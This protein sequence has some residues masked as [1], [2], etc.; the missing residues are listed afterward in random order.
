VYNSD[1][2]SLHNMWIA[3][4]N[5]ESDDITKVRGFLRISISVL[6]QKDDRV[7]LKC[8]SDS[9]DMCVVPPQIKMEYRQLKIYVIKARDLPNMDDYSVASVLGLGKG[10]RS[11]SNGECDGYVKLDYMGQSVKSSTVQ[12]KS[13]EILWNE[14]IQMAVSYPVI[15]QRLVFSVWDYD[16][17]GKDEIVGSFEVNVN[18]IIASKYNE[19][20]YIHLYGAPMNVNNTFSKKMDENPEVGSLWRGRILVRM[21]AE[22]T[23]SPINSLKA[24]N[25]TV[26]KEKIIIKQSNEVRMD[27]HWKLDFYLYDLFYLPSNAKYG[28]NIC[29]GEKS[30]QVELRKAVN[31]NIKLNITDNLFID[32]IKNMPEDI[33][34]IF[35][36]LTDETGIN[37]CFQR[38]KAMEFLNNKDV[39]VIKLFPDHTIGKIKC[40]FNSGIL[41]ARF[42][43]T[44][45]SNIQIPVE[46][47]P[48]DPTKQAIDSKPPTA[49]TKP[50]DNKNPP[51]KIEE[52]PES[53]ESFGLGD[54]HKKKQNDAKKVDVEKKVETRYT[55]V[56]NVH[57]SR[58]LV[59]MDRGGKSDPYVTLKV[60]EYEMKTGVKKNTLNGIWNEKL[61]FTDLE[62]DINDKSSWPIMLVK[63][64]D[65]DTFNDE[66][67]AYSYIWLSDSSYCIGAL[68]QLRPSYIQ[69]FL[70]V[71]N[72]P[73]GQLLCSFIILDQTSQQDLI[74]NHL[75]TFKIIP[76]VE[77]YSFEINILGLRGL[78][79]L[80]LLPIKKA[81]ID[82]DLQSINVLGDCE[83][84]GKLTLITTQPKQSGNHPTINTVIK[85]DA[86]LPKDKVFMSDLQCVVKD[87]LLKGL[88]KQ[89]LGIFI[90]PISKI[91]EETEREMEEDIKRTSEK[92]HKASQR[93]TK[94]KGMKF[95]E[96]HVSNVVNTE[97]VNLIEKLQ[98]DFETNKTNNNDMPERDVNNN[99]NPQDIVVELQ[100]APKIFDINDPANFIVYPAY[101]K[102]KVPGV[103]E[104]SKKF[105]LFDKEDRSKAPD[106]K[107]YKAI[108]FN[109]QKPP[110]PEQSVKHYRRIFPRPLEEC[111]ELGISKPF[112]E[113]PIKRSKFEDK[114]EASDMFEA[115]R[116]IKSK[117]IKKYSST[118][119]QNVSLPEEI[120]F[121]DKDFGIF[122]GVINICQKK[123]QT[124]FDEIVNTIKSK[125]PDIV[126][127]LKFL[128]KYEDLSR[129]ILNPKQV[130]IRIYI[131]DLKNLAKKDLL[132]ETDPY[133]IVKLGSTVI[134]DEVSCIFDKHTTGW[135]K[136]YELHTTLPGDGAL[137]VE[138]WDEDP[139][140]PDEL[141]GTTMID[142]EDR[143]FDPIWR[144]LKEKPIETRTLLHPDFE[145]P[146]GEV[147]LW[148]DIF[149]ASDNNVYKKV[150]ITP[151][152]EST[153]ELRMIVWETEDIPF[154]DDEETT[155]LYMCVIQGNTRES[156]DTHYRCQTGC[157]S[158]NWRIL[159]PVIY[160]NPD[161]LVTIQAYDNDL[162]T[163]DDFISK[164]T[165]D[166]RSIIEDCY[167][168][169]VPIKVSLSH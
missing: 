10:Q 27:F 138:V 69:L 80:N 60:G 146:Q 96:Q 98:H 152:P 149:E 107:Y 109:K 42:T 147:T 76:D 154:M 130:I 135:Y 11:K 134:N 3:L 56:A 75:P 2:H 65:K 101:M 77:L 58:H 71:S 90:L 16:M 23:D 119:G 145:Q 163:R 133:V 155:D 110:T 57:Q 50:V 34:D 150:D 124:E 35:I 13:R 44:S 24:L 104:T 91:I 112:T 97:S 22:K 8:N 87:Y 67:I 43:L 113:I 55:I 29:I 39:T 12:M 64:M 137:R 45:L 78:K 14:C 30:T 95:F 84:S 169:D 26:E 1:G 63:I 94:P 47:K 99:V 162:F 82:F 151:S 41:K 28:L 86:Y 7:E 140:F 20:R 49:G 156:T 70:P 118:T 153:F 144:D 66:I 68:K 102:Y 125:S 32:T 148:V 167:D 123:K 5:P 121:E 127:D 100:E 51:A 105:E 61:I 132:S 165:L 92:L 164:Y 33:P 108:G 88:I 157:G 126:Q 83:E 81:C 114:I 159:I 122:K 36:Y 129:R 168:L 103:K 116:D 143:Y 25:R 136:C 40:V 15:S 89:S 106:P 59:A 62:F 46:I 21:E 18:D 48:K 38:I 131:L 53:D 37:I 161:T 117:I 111:T 120:L 141:V 31:N 72:F 52:E 54:L 74:T 93:K 166:I 4:A 9:K 19:F 85:F 73:Q 115:L 6:N 142:L 17:V 158:F 79:P 128:T 160:P 139:L